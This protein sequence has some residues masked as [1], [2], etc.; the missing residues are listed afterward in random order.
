MARDSPTTDLYLHLVGEI[1]PGGL[2]TVLAAVPDQH[3][4]CADAPTE[5]TEVGA[6]HRTLDDP[7][8]REHDCD[9]ACVGTALLTLTAQGFITDQDPA[10]APSAT[11]S[12]PGPTSV[13][14]QQFG[15]LAD[16]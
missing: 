10:A 4:V 11:V 7:A 13:R 14:G 16:L 1:T 6:A 15:S 5:V 3:W 2:P 8:S 9:G 12:G